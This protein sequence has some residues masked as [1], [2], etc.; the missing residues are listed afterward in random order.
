VNYSFCFNSTSYITVFRC[1][2]LNCVRKTLKT[3]T[4]DFSWLLWP[5]GLDF[6]N[7]GFNET[8]N[9]LYWG[10]VVEGIPTKVAVKL[11]PQEEPYKAWGTVYGH[12]HAHVWWSEHS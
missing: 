1:I 12:C 2:V 6:I 8:K 3:Y 7:N 5:L 11:P 10:S 9:G 4:A